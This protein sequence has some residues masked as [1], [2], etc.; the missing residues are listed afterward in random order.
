MIITASEFIK[1]CEKFKLSRLQISYLLRFSLISQPLQIKDIKGSEEST[2]NLFDDVHIKEV[3]KL[4]REDIDKRPIDVLA[5]NSISV[6]SLKFINQQP[7]FSDNAKRLIENRFDLEDYAKDIV[8][9]NIDEFFNKVSS[10]SY[11]NVNGLEEL[12]A[13]SRFK[14]SWTQRLWKYLTTFR[15]IDIKINGKEQ[16][17]IAFLQLI[18]IA[19]LKSKITEFIF[20]RVKKIDY[21]NPFDKCLR[22]Y[23]QNHSKLGWFGFDEEI[24]TLNRFLS[25]YPNLKTIP[26]KDSLNF[27][28]SVEDEYSKIVDQVIEYLDHLD[29]DGLIKSMIIRRMVFKQRKDIEK[30]IDQAC[31]RKFKVLKVSKNIFDTLSKVFRGN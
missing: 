23:V 2:L 4:L 14:E 8:P 25:F 16:L 21:S 7:G 10:G 15:L 13:K 5:S 3:D 28:H 26:I 22:L 12:T 6:Q 24:Y 18:I 20:P 29:P 27:L 11:C 31:G 19:I 9:I 1:I 17:E 30:I